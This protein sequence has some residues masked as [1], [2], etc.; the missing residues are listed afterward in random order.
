MWPQYFVVKAD[1][2]ELTVE[3]IRNSFS[4]FILPL[5]FNYFRAGTLLICALNLRRVL[6]WRYYAAFL[7]RTISN[8]L[9]SSH[10]FRY[11]TTLPLT[12]VL[13]SIINNTY[14][15]VRATYLLTISRYCGKHGTPKFS[16]MSCATYGTHVT[17]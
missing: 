8:S 17:V 14:P 16:P 9:P 3:G 5:S 1:Y 2:G 13:A 15:T 4:F 11:N 10:H 7:E 12:L 6:H